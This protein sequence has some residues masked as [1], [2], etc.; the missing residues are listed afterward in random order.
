[1]PLVG[2]K[3]FSYTPKGMKQ[4]VAHAEKTGQKVRV[5]KKGLGG[6]VKKYNQGGPLKGPSHKKGGIPAVVKGGQPI[7]MEGG[8]YVIKKD[9]AKKLGP[10]I[11]NYI[12]K[13]GAV[14]KMNEGGSV[15][16]QAKTAETAA[17]KRRRSNPYLKDYLKG[18]EGVGAAKEQYLDDLS[19][20]GKFGQDALDL[21]KS[22]SD[23]K[24]YITGHGV[25][26]GH[27]VGIASTAYGRAMKGMRDAGKPMLNVLKRGATKKAE[28][29]AP[30]ESAQGNISM[31]GALKNL[32]HKKEAL[33]FMNP[34][35]ST[36]WDKYKEG[37]PVN[38]YMATAQGYVDAMPTKTGKYED[39]WWKDSYGNLGRRMVEDETR[40][41][42]EMGEGSGNISMLGRL[43]RLGHAKEA[44]RA[45]KNLANGGTVNPYLKDYRAAR[46]QEMADLGALPQPGSEEYEQ[47]KSRQHHTYTGSGSRAGSGKEKWRDYERSRRTA[48]RGRKQAEKKAK[49][50]SQQGM[51]IGGQSSMAIF[52]GLKARGH[53][54]AAQRTIAAERQERID[55]DKARQRA[56]YDAGKAAWEEE[57]SKPLGMGKRS[58]DPYRYRGYNAPAGTYAGGGMVGNKSL[59]S[60]LKKLG[61]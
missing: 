58:Y 11:L 27:G 34:D 56:E 9:S 46:E 26:Q 50:R 22:D 32:G 61:R 16:A 25:G 5:D 1:M 6:M 13:T 8:E 21:M 47:L 30:L 44:N 53:Q 52:G 43:K 39:D 37:G 29:R 18:Q 14:P 33:R 4:A 41:A 48:S 10:D 24:H 55:A 42:M 35:P 3:H 38:P 2:K 15:E 57:G 12:N 49:A 28:A 59:F 19:Y 23:G 60:L 36:V 20:R 51:G 40:G 45:V 17:Q 31:L 7:E 54:K